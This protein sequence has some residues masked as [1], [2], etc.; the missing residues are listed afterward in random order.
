LSLKRHLRLAPWLALTSWVLATHCAD[1][2]ADDCTRTLTCPSADDGVYYLDPECNWRGPNGSIWSNGPKND[3]TG[4]WRWADGSPVGQNFECGN[5]SLGGSGGS[6]GIAAGGSGGAGGTAAQG[7]TAGDGEPDGGQ[8]QPEEMPPDPNCNTNGIECTAP[9]ECDPVSGS[10]VGCV[11]DASCTPSAQKCLIEDGQPR[12]CV[13]CLA[14]ADCPLAGFARCDLD[15]HT[16]QPCTDPAQCGRF[17][18]T[19]LCSLVEPLVGKCVQ[20]LDNTQCAAPNARCKAET[21][22]CVQCTADEHC[23]GDRDN[24]HCDLVTNTCVPCSDGS[25]CPDA[26]PLCRD[27]QEGASCVQC[28]GDTGN[29]ACQDA[30]AAHC[31]DDGSCVECTVNTECTHLGA[32]AAVCDTSKTPNR[33]VQCVSNDDCDSDTLSQCDLNTNTCVQCTNN[34]GCAG[35]ANNRVVCDTTASPNRCVECTGTDFA[36][37]SIAGSPRVCNSVTRTC[38][39][40]APG[41]A[42]QCGECVSDAQCGTANLCVSQAL[43]TASGTFCM[44]QTQATGTPCGGLGAFRTAFTT[45][46]LDVDNVSICFPNNTCPALADMRLPKTCIANTD[47]GA[48]TADDGLC[49]TTDTG[50][51]CTVT[52]A[53][54]LDCPGRVCGA[55]NFCVLPPPMGG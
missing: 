7:G 54:G 49:V 1:P 47:C 23:A 11:N 45:D 4:V 29:N 50:L 44:P 17:T 41:S 51:Q 33:C 39:N 10:C 16:C 32:A 36:S 19:N 22:A 46:S 15:T 48:S 9:T 31:A 35:Q 12:A 53:D 24:A 13:A 6:G 38:T 55:S 2:L 21:G 42:D 26:F 3:G 52:C 30:A 14:D 20:C 25:Q 28:I 5:S 37:C 43:G 8:M 27:T 34:A 40:F 18:G